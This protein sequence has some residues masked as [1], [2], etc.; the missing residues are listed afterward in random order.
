[1]HGIETCSPKTWTA[2]E[3]DE[4]PRGRATNWLCDEDMLPKV[5]PQARIWVYDY[6]SYCYSGN[7][8]K[9][10]ILG[11]G[12][13]FLEMLR[14]AED[15]GVGKRSLVFIGSCFGGVVIAQVRLQALKTLDSFGFLPR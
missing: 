13:S 7:A 5:L 14:A 9:I 1:M 4:E 15:K 8:Q 6:N 2:Y 3:R 10:D 12:D 11:L